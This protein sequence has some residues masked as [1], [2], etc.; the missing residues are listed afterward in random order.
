VPFLVPALVL[1]LAFAA[2][3]KPAEPPPAQPVESAADKAAKVAEANK[4]TAMRFMNE[5]ATAGKLE[6][7]DEIVDPAFVE[8]VPLP[9]DVPKGIEGLKAFIKGYRQAF[10]DTTVTVEQITAS[11]DLVSV[12][13]IWKGT[14]KGDWMGF[15]ATNQPME[16]EVI[17]IVKIKDGKATDHWGMDDSE[18]KMAAAAKKK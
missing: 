16:F 18:R 5:V 17:D 12:R 1:T 13:S 11:D 15:K 8:H 6:V 2:C 4:A 3:Q 9:P 10:P 14:H 7:I